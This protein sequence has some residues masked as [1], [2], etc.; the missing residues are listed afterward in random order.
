VT[1]RLNINTGFGHLYRGTEGL[2]GTNQNHDS[3][4]DDENYGH[5]MQES[6]RTKFVNIPLNRSF[7]NMAGVKAGFKYPAWYTKQCVQYGTENQ[8]G[9]RCDGGHFFEYHS[10]D[11]CRYDTRRNEATLIYLTAPL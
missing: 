11:K 8:R 6:N 5:V 9:F 7:G 3:G 2:N 1:I 10:D 4:Q